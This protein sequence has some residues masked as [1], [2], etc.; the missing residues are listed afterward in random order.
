MWCQSCKSYHGMREEAKKKCEER[1]KAAEEEEVQLLQ[2][3]EERLLQERRYYNDNRERPSSS[4]GESPTEMAPPPPPSPPRVNHAAE[5]WAFYLEREEQKRME[6]AGTIEKETEPPKRSRPS[7]LRSWIP[8]SHPFVTPSTFQ[9]QPSVAPNP[10][11]HTV[12]SWSLPNPDA[13]QKSLHNTPFTNPTME[14]PRG[15][16]ENFQRLPPI[17]TKFF[18]PKPDIPM[19]NYRSNSQ[20]GLTETGPRSEPGPSP[21][22]D[23]TDQHQPLTA[24]SDRKD[25][26]QREEYYFSPYAASK[27]PPPAGQKQLGRSRQAGISQI[28]N[29]SS[30]QRSKS[31]KRP[32]AARVKRPRLPADQSAR[33]STVRGRKRKASLSVK[34]LLCADK[35]GIDTVD[36]ADAQAPARPS[37]RRRLSSP[38]SSSAAI[39]TPQPQ[40]S[41]TSIFKLIR[42]EEEKEVVEEAEEDKADDGDEED[43]IESVEPGG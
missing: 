7:Q 14:P 33:Q 38:S 12:Q 31:T 25:D 18:G 3:E 30:K 15:A 34:D 2:E 4:Q 11:E 26:S 29:Q 6:S 28:H 13:G 27:T 37:T 10:G 40:R 16:I 19:Q 20:Q 39:I 5:A 23:L 9:N 35:E 1:K 22:S 36:F 41:S 42:E 43:I 21:Y 17:N 24:V 32:S 8:I